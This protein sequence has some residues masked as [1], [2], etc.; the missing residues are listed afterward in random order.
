VVAGDLPLNGGIDASGT[1]F[2][3]VTG[4]MSDLDYLVF[5]TSADPNVFVEVFDS[6]TFL[7][8]G[9]SFAGTPPCRGGVANAAGELLLL[10]SGLPGTAFS[11]DVKELPV[12]PAGGAVASVDTTEKYYKVAGL[13]PGL[14]LATL[15]DL[16][17]DAELAVYGGP[18]GSLAGATPALCQSRNGARSANPV[19]FNTEGAILDESCSP[20]VPASGV[21][22]VSVE[23]WLTF[24]SDLTGT[25]FT[26]NVQ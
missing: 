3:K 18:S 9:L 11:L 7:P 2:Y 13:T 25:Q 24:P 21:V 23:G 26:L 10:V 6:T 4:L 8:V 16:T 17:D 22:Y 19:T 14:R 12:L 1:P 20:T 5:L 15:T